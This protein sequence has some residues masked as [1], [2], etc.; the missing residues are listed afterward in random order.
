MPIDDYMKFLPDYTPD[1][2]DQPEGPGNAGNVRYYDKRIYDSQKWWATATSLMGAAGAMSGA[3]VGYKLRP[4][5][6]LGAT[7]GAV[8]GALIGIYIGNQTPP[9]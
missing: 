8:V 3:C 5:S 1:D 2:P 6:P 9:R 7:V 4:A